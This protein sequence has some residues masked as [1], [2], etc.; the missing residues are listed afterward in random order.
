MGYL[1]K[2]GIC[3]FISHLCYIHTVY[4]IN[5]MKVAVVKYFKS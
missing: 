2:E 4:G 3:S 5:I 1:F